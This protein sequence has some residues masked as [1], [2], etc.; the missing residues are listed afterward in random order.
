M[1]DDFLAREAEI[2]DIVSDFD[3]DKF[4]A[5]TIDSNIY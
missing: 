5:F 2:T 1:V 3:K 4:R